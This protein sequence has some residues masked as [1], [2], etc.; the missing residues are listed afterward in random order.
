MSSIRQHVTPE[1]TDIHTDIRPDIQIDIQIDIDELDGL[2]VSQRPA[3]SPLGGDCLAWERLGVG[4]RCETWLAWS[5]R[6]F[7]PVVVK[8]PRP[9]QTTHPR[10][11]RSLRREVSA[12][13]GNLHPGLARLYDDGTSGDEPYLVLEF[14]DGIA[15]D[16]EIAGNGPL[17]DVE[18]ALLGLQVLAA[19]RTVHERGLV[20]VDLKPEN[21]MLRQGKPVVVD[22]GS[23]RCAGAEQP[24]GHLIGSPGYAAPELEAGAPIAA[25]MDL[26]GLGVTL[27]EAFTG[28]PA[29]DP[30][31]AA[32][33]RPAHPSLPTGR[34]GELLSQLLA[35]EPAQR[36]AAEQTMQRL[37]DIAAGAGTEAWPPF[38]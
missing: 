13:G 17:S 21:I 24:P 27:Y 30:E 11:R 10:A 29:F 8:L 26:F 9:H 3:G 31:L 1:G 18:T 33:Q 37:M 23:A 28:R 15:L 35:V 20:H 32:A 36:P 25:A 19:L 14:V 22:F 7:A 2:P 4:H 5:Q 38:A 34:L 16:D 6:M 12:L